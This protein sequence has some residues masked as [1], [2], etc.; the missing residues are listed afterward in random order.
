MTARVS[1]IAAV[2]LLFTREHD[3]VAKL[4]VLQFPQPG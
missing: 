3:P 2:E 1:H 4:A